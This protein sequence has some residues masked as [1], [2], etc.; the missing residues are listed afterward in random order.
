[1][2]MRIGG[3]DGET[4]IGLGDAG[5]GAVEQQP[6]IDN[7]RVE[8]RPPDRRGK[9]ALDEILKTQKIVSGAGL[10]VRRCGLDGPGRDVAVGRAL[11]AADRSGELIKPAE[12]S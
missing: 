8:Y 3:E 11:R 6:P 2:E 4:P 1:D 10:P 9:V 7:D 12:L 5:D